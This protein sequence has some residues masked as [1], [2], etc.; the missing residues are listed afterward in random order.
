MISFFA[1]GYISSRFLSKALHQAL[2]DR[3]TP[4]ATG[5]EEPLHRTHI[6]PPTTLNH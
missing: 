2:L 1:T 6:E 5:D 3:E 4:Q